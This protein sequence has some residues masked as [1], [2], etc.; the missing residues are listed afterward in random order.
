MEQLFSWPNTP[1]KRCLDARRNERNPT[2][3]LDSSNKNTIDQ[4]NP[5][6]HDLLV[7]LIGVSSSTRYP[8]LIILAQIFPSFGKILRI[9]V[10]IEM[11]D[12]SLPMFLG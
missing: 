3:R 9:L 10:E 6:A 8:L 1:E 11:G 7:R 2:N 4:K 12:I 5:T